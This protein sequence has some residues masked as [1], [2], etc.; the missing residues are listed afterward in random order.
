MSGKNGRTLLTRVG[1]LNS[2]SSVIRL[3]W[4]LE[5]LFMRFN[6]YT[7]S[8][9]ICTFCSAISF[10]FPKANCF[11]SVAIPVRSA[12]SANNFSQDSVFSVTA[13]FWT[14]NFSFNS[15]NCSLAASNLLNPPSSRWHLKRRK[16]FVLTTLRAEIFANSSLW[17][18]FYR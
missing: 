18:K 1:Y 15:T 4:N 17:K 12:I 14:A 8:L 5:S 3:F 6:C 9:T 7:F 11:F 16:K 2:Y 10:F 13:T